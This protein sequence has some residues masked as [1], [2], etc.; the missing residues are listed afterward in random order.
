MSCDARLVEGEEDGLCFYATY[1]DAHDVRQA[2]IGITENLYAFDSRR[3]SLQETCSPA[4][5]GRL[6]VEAS[7]LGEDL[8]CGTEADDRGN[9]LESRP[10]GTLLVTAHYERLDV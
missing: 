7:R 8:C 5:L 10:P 3:H 2:V 6:P 1:G 4:R 9:V